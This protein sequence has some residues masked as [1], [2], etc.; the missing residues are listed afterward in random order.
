M[1]GAK[2]YP[3][4]AGMSDADL[5]ALTKKCLARF[6]AAG[7]L[8]L[9][10]VLDQRASTAASSS[11]SKKDSAVGTV[12]ITLLVVLVVI[13]IVSVFGV[14]YVVR[15]R[16]AKGECPS[17]VARCRGRRGCNTVPRDAFDRIPEPSW[18]Q[19]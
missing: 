11:G 9:S 5:E 4:T 17:F 2:A 8:H 7:C 3:Y 19:I 6:T 10:D 18:P 13:V 12:L 16:A 1:E 14:I 15:S